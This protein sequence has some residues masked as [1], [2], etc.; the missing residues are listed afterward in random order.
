MVR[1][2]LGC[3]QCNNTGYK[4]RIAVHE[5]LPI[6]MELR[7]MIS[8]DA[9]MEEVVRY[10]VAHQGMRP[11]RDSVARLVMEGVTTPEEMLK[12]AYE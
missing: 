10:G 3:S 4:G 7:R 5:I 11:L 12:I 1:R 9:S 6:D 2:G 8:A